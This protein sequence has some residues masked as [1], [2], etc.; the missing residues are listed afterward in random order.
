MYSKFS[1]KGEK[2]SVQQKTWRGLGGKMFGG[3]QS[4][5]TENQPGTG[6]KGPRIERITRITNLD[7]PAVLIRQ[8]PVNRGERSTLVRE[9]DREML[10]SR[11]VWMEFSVKGLGST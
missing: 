3:V 11:N 10:I 5:D 8:I 9:P 4:I 1:G 2:C 7:Q 6:L